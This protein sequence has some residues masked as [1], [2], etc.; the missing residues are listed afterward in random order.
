MDSINYIVLGQRI[1]LAR[2]SKN[3]TQEQLAEL[4]DLSTSHIGL[5]ERAARIPSLEAL[6]KIACALDVSMDYL[7]MRDF[8]SN[9]LNF[10][11][12]EAYI[13]S[14]DKDKVDRLLSLISI[15]A[16]NLDRL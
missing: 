2:E 9:S 16:E 7:L 8:P 10:N 15:L 6:Y 1:R 3:F 12:L 14:R 4:C 13:R 5:V 11:E